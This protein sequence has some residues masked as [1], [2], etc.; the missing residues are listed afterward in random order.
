VH[1]G[2]GPHLVS[3]GHGG[4][5]VLFVGPLSEPEREWAAGRCE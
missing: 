4:G 5:V 3:G 2:Q 1:L